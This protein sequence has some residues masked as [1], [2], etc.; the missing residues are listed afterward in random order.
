MNFYKELFNNVKLKKG[1]GVELNIAGVV[2]VGKSSLSAI[3]EEKGY[4]IYREPVFD[5]P[6]LD[7]FYFNKEIQVDSGLIGSYDSDLQLRTQGTTRL[8]L[9]N[10]TGNATFGGDVTINGNLTVP[11]GFMIQDSAGNND[12]IEFN[13]TNRR[14]DFK[15]DG[16]T[17]LSV[18]N[19][20][21][22]IYDD[23]PSY[24]L[25][26][27]GTIRATTRIIAPNLVKCV[28][29]GWNSGHDTT[30]T[31]RVAYP[32]DSDRISCNTDYMTKSTNVFTCVKAGVYQVSLNAMALIADDEYVHHRIRLN[33]AHY[34]QTHGYG[35]D[36]TRR[37]HDY[38]YTILVDL[39]VNDYLTFDAY[40]NSGGYLWH[41]GHSYSQFSIVYLDKS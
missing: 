4:V 1:F 15:I 23:T 22:G 29:A 20:Y 36:G 10:S 19:G 14:I 34:F 6:L 3:L 38:S 27:A 40:G 13:Q 32:L 2:G 12:E 21:V 30:W 11:N 37:W 39:S 18:G 5:N 35:P 31:E 8:T 17:M 16:A 26:V 9:S 25:D 24:E 41:G 7:K 33:N 28:Y